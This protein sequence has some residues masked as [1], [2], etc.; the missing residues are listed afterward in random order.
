MPAT[1][2]PTLD[3]SGE[4]LLRPAPDNRGLADAWYRSA[5]DWGSHAQ[6]AHVPG[7]WQHTLGPDYHGIAWYT[8]TI[9]IPA[10]WRPSSAERLRLRFDSVATDA[11]VWINGIEVGSH[12]GDYVPFEFDITDAATSA[13]DLTLCVRVD[14]VHA[15]RPPAGDLVE[16]G[17]ITKGF[18]DVLSLQHGGIWGDVTVRVTGKRTIIPDGIRV[19]A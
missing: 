4:A 8:R 3:L 18:H 13:R 14:E 16:R 2:P 7:A 12:S 19:V 1:T 6:P 10:S 17:H 5:T 15:P 11:T 9:R